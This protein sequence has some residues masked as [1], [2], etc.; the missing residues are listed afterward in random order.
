MQKPGK[1]QLWLA[2][3]CLVCVIAALRN[4]SDLE[5][6]EF[7][8]GWLTGP[9]LSMIDIGTVLFVLALIVTFIFPRIAGAIGL[10]SSLLCLPLYLY[11]IAPVT[12]SQIFGVGHQFKVQP[13][14]GF[15]WDKWPIAG[16]LTL[17]ANICLC[18]RGFA[19][20]GRTQIPERG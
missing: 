1:Q 12:F 18:L 16:V 7:S 19:V 9:L 6:T 15:H 4:T 13:S 20:T 17:A 11:F 8:G 3:S 2:V 5:G 10:A 14:G